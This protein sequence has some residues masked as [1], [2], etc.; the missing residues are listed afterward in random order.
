M[1]IIVADSC[2]LILLAKCGMLEI[3]VGTIPV[4]TP[5]GVYKEV[6]NKKLVKK[7][8]DAAVVSD[9][10]SKKLIKVV[11]VKH[12]SIKIP[13]SMDRGEIEALVLASRTAA[14]IVATDD[15]KAIMACRYLKMP[16]IISPKIAIELYRMGKIDFERVKLGVEKMRIIGRYSV[17]IIAE[18]LIELEAIKNAKNS[19]G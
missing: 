11:P 15:R 6:V 16:F 4:I 19:H 5:E 7:Y 1:N 17:D 13:I 3:L 14:S 9:L 18:A 2:A 12:K 8:A 10:V